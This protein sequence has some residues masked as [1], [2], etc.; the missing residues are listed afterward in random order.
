MVAALMTLLMPGAGPPPTRI[1]RLLCNAKD[2]CEF[3]L[4]ERALIPLRS[5]PSSRK[6]SQIGSLLPWRLW[7]VHCPKLVLRTGS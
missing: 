3:F 6:P 2:A 5:H 1:A 7:H 4:S